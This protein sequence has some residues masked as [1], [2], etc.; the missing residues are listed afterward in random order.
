MNSVTGIKQIDLS[1]SAL[2]DFKQQ[3]AGCIVLTSDNRILVQQRP[4]NWRTF[5]GMITT[6]GGH[7]E[8]KESP[9]EAIIR[10]LH[11]ELG[12]RVELHDLVS[13][14]AITEE[15]TEHTE[16]IYLYFGH[17]KEKTITGCYECEPY[18]FDTMIDLLAHPKVM[19][20]VRWAI[21]ECQR[22]KLLNH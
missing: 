9:I 5:P 12:A 14:G 17:D 8:S 10:E 16:L 22:Q 4:D 21:M 6:F 2:V 19:Q 1:K 7:L 13:L 20:E 3:H 15:I 18:Y 11:E